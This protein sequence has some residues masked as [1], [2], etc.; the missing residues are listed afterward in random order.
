MGQPLL[1]AAIAIPPGTTEND[2]RTHQ[3]V[4]ES[5]GLQVCNIVDEPT[6]ANAV[7]G[8]KDGVIVDIGGGT[9]GLSILKDGQVV[10]VVDEAT[11][12]HPC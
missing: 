7:I 12:G 8:M 1:H 9:T 3:Y 5:T 4:V 11:G 10:F 6:A 2:T